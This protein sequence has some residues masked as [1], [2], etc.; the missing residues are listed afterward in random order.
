MPRSHRRMALRDASGVLNPFF[1]TKINIV[2]TDEA[3]SSSPRKTLSR[4]SEDAGL[5]VSIKLTSV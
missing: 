1:L 5:Q 2:D 4:Q 3:S